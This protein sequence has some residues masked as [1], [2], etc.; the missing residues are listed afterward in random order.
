MCRRFDTITACDR[1]RDGQT[2]GIAVACTAL[3]MRAL[4]RAV[5]SGNTPE[6]MQQ[7]RIYGLIMAI[8][9][10]LSDLQ[11]HVPNEG[12]LKCDFSYICA[13]VDEISTDIA[14]RAVPLRHLSSSHSFV[15][16]LN[17]KFS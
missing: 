11:D 10:T 12:R 17:R 9:M 5:K 15:N 3:A 2:D 1:R 4:R 7:E 8:P 6:T 14:R 16:N 13:A